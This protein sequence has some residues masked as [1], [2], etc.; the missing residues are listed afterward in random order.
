[1]PQRRPAPR[2]RRRWPPRLAAA[3]AI[4]I[5]VFLAV[6][7]FPQPLFAHHLRYEQYDLWSDRPIPPQAAAAVLDDATRRLARSPLWSPGQRFSV[8]ICNDNWRLALY[9]QR[10]SGRM[11]GV[12]D[13]NF[14]RNVFLRSADIAANRLIP[15]HPGADMSDRPLS[16]YVAHEITHALESRSFGRGTAARYP[17]W[18][19]EGY[20]DYIGKGGDFDYAKNLAL[21]KAR[22]PELDFKRSGLYRVYHLEV[23]DYLDRRHM[24]VAQLFAAPPTEAQA[25]AAA[26]LGP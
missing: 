26:M 5:A 23:A 24:T 6:I 2:G 1:M 14:T 11:G 8:F 10:F 22:A 7:Y 25:L 9:S 20:A 15:P 21:L 19:L 16:Y 3:G 12:T 18:L 4:L 17:H 13:M